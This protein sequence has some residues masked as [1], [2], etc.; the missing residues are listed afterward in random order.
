MLWR[1][2]AD[3]AMKKNIGLTMIITDKYINILD[4]SIKKLQRCTA[5]GLIFK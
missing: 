3:F 5:Y 2:I 1:E 4:Y